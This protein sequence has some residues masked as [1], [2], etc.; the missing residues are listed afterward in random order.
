MSNFSSNDLNDWKEY[1][2]MVHWFSPMVLLKTA[3]KVMDSTLFGQYA[4]RRLV[5]AALDSPIDEKTLI[6][7]SC[8]GEEGICGQKDRS[9][10]WVDYVADLGDGFDSTYAI[11]YLI[12]QK[13]L[14][15]NDGPEL[16]R[17]DCLIMG[18]DQV[19]P[20]AS[21]EEYKIRMQRPYRAAFPR[22]TKI[23]ASHPRLFLIPGNHDWYD[24]LNL[25]LAMFC[26]G[27]E[28]PL[29]S[30][31]A[32]QKR[33]YFSVH[34]GQNWWIWGFDS[35]LGEDI[36]KPQ[37]DYFDAVAKQ[38]KAGANVILCASVPT[39]LKAD[40]AGDK[41]GSD[42]YYRALHFIANKIYKKCDG[43]KIPLVIS[44]DLHHYSRY[45]GKESGTNFIT[46]GGGGAFLHP[47]HHLSDAINIKWPGSTTGHETLVIAETSDATKGT[48]AFYPPQR[49]SKN[50]TLG[51]IWFIFKNP[52]F[53]LLLG[54][55]Y[56]V[57]ALLMLAWRGYGETGAGPLLNRFLI[58]VNNLWP[59][60]VFLLIFLA[61]AV[62]L[63][64]SA[65]ISSKRRR[66]VIGFLHALFHAGII[67]FGT[68]F[69]SAAIPELPSV[70]L[71]EV[72]YFLFLVAGM[73]GFGFVGGFVWGIYLMVVSYLWGDHANG[74]FGAMRLDSYRHFIRLKIEGDRLTIYPI[75]IDE[76]P[77]RKDWI[78]NPDYKHED[79][80]QDTPFI[81]PKSNQLIRPRLIEA[82]VEINLS[83]ISS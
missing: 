36:D 82:E 83:N 46:A 64:V 69:V 26:N 13:N 57:C 3:K 14:Q 49:E 51:N 70:F 67:L 41:K 34:L 18:G 32:K 10:I 1:R 6:K 20:D 58:Q 24:G 81:T 8:G 68:A 47:T 4:D 27:Q 37:S 62:A 72:P 33:S 31:I 43:S 25:F 39:W 55:L 53:C 61:L 60:P 11:A 56:S 80:D 74:A 2:G 28:T 73:V 22:T 76:S 71:Y 7:E 19:Y 63:V 30:W 29:G 77:R 21:R 45:E 40:L 75:G 50:L 5:H 38:M 66:Y 48:K 35:Q 15:I 44:G 78:I 12:G 52:D 79:V 16:P 17:A 9:E 59:T 65:E 54:G 42:E 23:G